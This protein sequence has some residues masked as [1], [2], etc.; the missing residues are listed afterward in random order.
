MDD[1]RLI[2]CFVGAALTI[3]G[4]CMA[5]WPARLAALNQDKDN[6]TAPPSRA[7][8][9]RTRVAGMLLAVSGA[10]LFYDILSGTLKPAKDPVLF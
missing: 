4:G 2:G 3:L 1:G 10:F 6:T 7:T 8:V 9:W 5:L